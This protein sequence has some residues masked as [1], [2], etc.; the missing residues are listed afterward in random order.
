[1]IFVDFSLKRDDMIKKSGH[2]A[3]ITVLDHH[4]TAEENLKDIE[5]ELECASEIIFDMNRAGCEIA[6]DYFM[7]SN[8]I[9]PMVLEHIADRDLWL[10]KHNNTKE[11]SLSVFSYEYTFENWDYLMNESNY[12]ELVMGGEAIERKHMK[13]VKE[14]FSNSLIWRDIKVGNKTHVVP[15][16]N[17]P[18][19][20]SSELGHYAMNT[21]SGYVPF[22]LCWYMDNE[23]KYK[24]SLRSL[25]TREDVSEI[26][27]SFGGGGHRN[28]AGFENKSFVWE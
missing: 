20:Y 1:L 15:T 7:D 9:K 11:I 18:Y 21:L 2:A 28:A 23:G 19:F 12:A 10:F 22:S 5:P 17:V 6:W 13:D 26:A 16:F 27:K 25:D 3:S 8:K 24:Y 4:K 14:L